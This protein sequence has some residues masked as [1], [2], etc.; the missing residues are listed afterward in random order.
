[1]SKTCGCCGRQITFRTIDGQ[2]IPLGCACGSRSEQPSRP[3]GP[4]STGAVALPWPV[5]YHTSCWW[6]REPVFYHTNGYGDCVLFD[7]LGPPWPVHHCW[8]DH[9]AERA[10]AVAQI[11]RGVV[12]AALVH[13]LYRH[14]SQFN[15]DSLLPDDPRWFNIRQCRDLH[16][17][18]S[19]DIPS[20]RSRRLLNPR[21]DE[22]GPFLLICRVWGRSSSSRAT[23]SARSATTWIGI[24]VDVGGE[25]YVPRHI[26]TKLVRGYPLIAE[27]VVRTCCGGPS[28]FATR[29]LLGDQEFVESTVE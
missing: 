10:R 26:V 9:K 27:I 5:S 17:I 28:F 4:S 8:E 14:T 12:E 16:L 18:R 25:I 29:I 24:E 23:F 15:Q 3:L 1:M 21:L 20:H 19:S 6:C 13:N 11:R 2:V 7:Q 22:P